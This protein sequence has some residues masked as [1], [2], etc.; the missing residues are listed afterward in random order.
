MPRREPEKYLY[1]MLSSCEF[2]LEFTAG[3]TVDDYIN[4]RA[5]RSA[6]ERE[7]QIIGEALIHLELLAPTIAAQI[8]EHQNIIG[9]R[10]VLVHGYDSLDPMTV[11]NVIETKLDGLSEKIK[12]LLD[13]NR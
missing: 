8:P 4:E 10:H 11:W 1:D 6:V 9:F 5:F 12:S 7:L 3:K 2:L 13:V